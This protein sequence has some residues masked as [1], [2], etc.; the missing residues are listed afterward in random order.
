VFTAIFS[1]ILLGDKLSVQNITGMAVVIAG[2][3]MSQMNSR[4]KSLDEA[5]A[6]TGKTA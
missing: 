4:I 1:F 6:L 5:M 2:L 3:F